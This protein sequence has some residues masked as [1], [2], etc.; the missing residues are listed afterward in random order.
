MIAA[1]RLAP[2]LLDRYLARTNVDAQQADIPI[3][4]NR[5]DYL[6]APLPG[7]RGA[8]GR[9]SDEAKSR[10][11]QWALAKHRGAAAMGAGAVL[12]GAAAAGL[13]ARRS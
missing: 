8:R 5:P 1:N 13:A 10:S 12:A 3:D 2:G 9:F 11:I 4:P 6:Y 7:D